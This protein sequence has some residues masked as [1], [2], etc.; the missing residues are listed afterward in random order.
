MLLNKNS[1]TLAVSEFLF[2]YSSTRQFLAASILSEK[3]EPLICKLGQEVCELTIQAG[4]AY[5]KF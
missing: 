4:L 2:F 1:E 3:C 5:P